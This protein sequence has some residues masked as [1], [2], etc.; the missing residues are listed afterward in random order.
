MA[1]GI[2]EATGIAAP[3]CV[4]SR[5]ED[6]RSG[7]LGLG[8]DGVHVAALA[9]VIGQR[10]AAETGAVVLEARVQGE[11]GARI[12]RHDHPAG[13]VKDDLFAVVGAPPSQAVF[14]ET[15]RALEIGDSERDDTEP[16]F[17]R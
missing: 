13:L 11:G 6:A 9:H 1:V 15:A 3:E 17:H 7:R 16:L 2:G 12:E 5:F 8:Q 10:D 14:I 4:P